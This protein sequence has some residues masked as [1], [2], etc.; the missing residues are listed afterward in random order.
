[1]NGQQDFIGPLE[2]TN[3][4]KALKLPKRVTGLNDEQLDQHI[5]S[6]AIKFYHDE[7]KEL[8][9]QAVSTL[10]R[11]RKCFLRAGTGYGKTRISEMYFNLFKTKV[12]V[13]VLNPLDSLGDDQV[14]EKKIVKIKSVNLNKMMLNRE[15]IQKIKSGYFGFVY[16][17]PEVFL[18]NNLFTE[19]FFSHEFQKILALM[20]IDEAHM[21]YL[22]GLVTSKAAKG[23]A[24]FTRHEDRGPFRIAYG[25]IATRLMATN[26]IPVLMLSAT[27]RPIAVS[28]II[29]NLRLQPSDITMIDGELTRPE[30]R[31]IRIPMK[32]TLK[33]CDDLLRIFAPQSKVPA[34]K[35]IPMLIYSSS[36][37][38][39][40]QVMK[41]VNEARH[42]K[43]HEY[44]PLD[45]F[46]RRYHSVTGEEDKADNMKDYMESKFPV[47]SATMALGLG[48]NLKRVRCVIHMG[49]GDPASIVQM[50]GRCG[51]DGST[52]LALLFMEPVRQKGKN[53]VEDFDLGAN[54]GEDDRVDAMAVSPVCL[55]VAINMDNKHGYIPLEADDRNYVAE[56]SREVKVGFTPCKC[57][58]CCPDEAAQIINV[59]QQ[60]D[61]DNFHAILDNPTAI[62]L[63][64]S[65][66]TLTRQKKPNKGPATCKL[67]P[68]DAAHL[69]NHLVEDFKSF[70]PELLAPDAKFVP[71]D[72]FGPLDAVELVASFDQIFP[73]EGFDTRH[74]QDV[75][76]GPWFP[77]QLGWLT[78]AAE[79]RE[80]AYEILEEA[81]ARAAEKT[82]QQEERKRVNDER[83]RVNDERKAAKKHIS[84]GRNQAT[85]KSTRMIAEGHIAAEHAARAAHAAEEEKSRLEDMKKMEYLAEY[86]RL[87]V[88]KQ[89]ERTQRILAVN[90]AR[91]EAEHMKAGEKIAR[92]EAI[93]SNKQRAEAKRSVSIRRTDKKIGR[94]SSDHVGWELD[95]AHLGSNQGVSQ[96]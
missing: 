42:T 37:N 93:R 88:I 53:S 54:Q 67:S 83:K 61:K 72:F 52:G 49:R 36:R 2:E 66:V 87:E 95:Q 69:A 47:M 6:E 18:N 90:Q 45:G 29:S 71:A 74:L 13:L 76:G 16:L 92:K 15:V 63:D 17:S 38:L 23:M 79:V 80:Q 40:F 77:G 5:R 11:G 10:A 85:D 73:V 27:C 4:C 1:M 34:E 82:F 94:K 60:I 32:F 96:D 70:M 20:V 22:W 81:T 8:Q 3:S 55:R 64:T 84:G 26:N 35:A 33:S 31:I 41:V 39:T 50:I 65:I 46:I 24:T 86:T 44:D 91:T 30:I 89:T 9:V 51:R 48:Q 57:S 19:M 28:S 62:P 7:P 12:V 56:R 43:K 58:N 59:F 25:S 68:V 21:V 75:I 78:G 14:R